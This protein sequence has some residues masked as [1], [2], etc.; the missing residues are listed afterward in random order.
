MQRKRGWLWLTTGILLALLAGVLTFRTL[1][2]ATQAAT[3]AQAQEIDM[4]P[5][6]VAVQDIPMRTE[7]KESQVAVKKVPTE[8]VPLGAATVLDD[9]VG[10]IARQDIAAGEI[11]LTRRLVEPTVTGHDVVF[12]MPEDKV[13]IALP[14]A[15]LMSRIGFLKPGDRVDLLFT[16][17]VP[18]QKGDERLVTID[19]LQNLEITAIAMPP[20]QARASDK[21]KT[22]R[23]PGTILA[24]EGVL[25]F[26]VDPQDALTLKYLKDS[27]AIMDVALRAPTNEQQFITEPVDRTYVE[28][29]YQIIEPSFMLEGNTGP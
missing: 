9:V 5:V 12:T 24:N 23:R 29:R 28:D 17:A 14:A 4:R 16:I 1:E 20:L 3:Q 19:A 15:D 18:D 13:L 11:V 26:A 8:L 6:V 10:K 21:T 27:G 22:T 25:M 7:I 2:Q